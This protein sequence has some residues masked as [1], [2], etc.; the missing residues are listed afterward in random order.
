MKI[1][2]FALFLIL[3]MAVLVSGC[4]TVNEGSYMVSEDHVAVDSHATSSPRGAVEYGTDDRMMTHTTLADRKTITTVDMTIR[5]TDAAG[6]VDGISGLAVSYGG[7]V[8]SSSVYDSYRGESGTHK[9]GYVTVRIP[10]DVYTVFVEGVG[11]LGEVTHKSVNAQDV[12]EEY[13]D[14]SARLGN[15]KK[16][17]ARL[18]DILDMAD[19]VEEVLSVEKELERVRGQIESLTGRLNYLEDRTDY[20][21]INIRVTE[22]RPIS[23]SWGIRDAV[24]DSF[25]AF[26]S[27]VGAL[28]VLV[29]YLLPLIIVFTVTGAIIVM[30]WRKVRR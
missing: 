7:Y 12:T 3:L 6:A 19:S 16:Q 25:N 18:L 23:G 2:D 27:T 20:S 11:N 24:S 28:I 29:G 1:K 26:T 10:E 14:I 8:S 15:L 22:P 17:E 4:M 21:T 13:V 5:V 9:E 30:V